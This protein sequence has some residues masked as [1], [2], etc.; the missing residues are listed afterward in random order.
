MRIEAVID[1]AQ[2]AVSGMWSDVENVEP[3][4]KPDMAAQEIVAYWESEGQLLSP[5]DL[6]DWN[7]SC[8]T[9]KDVDELRGRAVDLVEKAILANRERN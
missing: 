1:F 6:E 9:E 3:H 7:E 2:K 8:P 5:T 4:E